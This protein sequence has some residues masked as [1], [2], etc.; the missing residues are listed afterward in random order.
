MFFYNTKREDADTTLKQHWAHGPCFLG[1]RT[2]VCLFEDNH[3]QQTT[4][5]VILLPLSANADPEDRNDHI[6]WFLVRMH[7]VILDAVG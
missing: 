7:L 3:V 2:R 5:W 4:W 1:N 6:S